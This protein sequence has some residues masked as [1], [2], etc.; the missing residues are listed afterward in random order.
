MFCSCLYTHSIF[1]NI[2]VI[3]ICEMFFFPSSYLCIGESFIASFTF[4]AAGVMGMHY[5]S[6]LDVFGQCPMPFAFGDNDTGKTTSAK[7]LFVY[8]WQAS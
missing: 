3:L 1:Y 5:E 6:L 2:L 7:I 8:G 4:I